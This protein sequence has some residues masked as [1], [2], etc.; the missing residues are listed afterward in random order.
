MG[1]VRVWIVLQH[2]YY[3]ERRPA[4]VSRGYAGAIYLLAALTRMACMRCVGSGS[5]VDLP[6]FAVS[7]SSWL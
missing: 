7:E 1:W 3:W 2:Y 4:K 6:M 5:S